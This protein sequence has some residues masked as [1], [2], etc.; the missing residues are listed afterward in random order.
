MLYLCQERKEQIEK[1]E[2]QERL[3]KEKEEKERNE[4]QATK[5]DDTKAEDTEPKPKDIH[6][7]IGLVDQ[8]PQVLLIW[9]Y[10]RSYDG[11]NLLLAL[12]PTELIHRVH[13]E[14]K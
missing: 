9:V 3:Q 10:P 5:D 6:D 11:F 2:E 1:A 7:D 13:K 4:A 8:P 12:K 14:H